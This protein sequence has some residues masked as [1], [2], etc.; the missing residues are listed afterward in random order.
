MV[1]GG[2][3]LFWLVLGSRG[4][5]WVVVSGFGSFLVLVCTS[6]REVLPRNSILSRSLKIRNP[7]IGKISLT[8]SPPR[9]FLKESSLS[10]E[11]SLSISTFSPSDFH[12]IIVE[13]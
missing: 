9:D 6:M 1:V 8:H 7:I 3:G 5:L 10:P 11:K 2:V 12:R 13:D 4:L